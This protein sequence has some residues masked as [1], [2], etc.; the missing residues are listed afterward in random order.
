MQRKKVNHERV[1]AKRGG[2]TAF[3]FSPTR[4]PGLR[5]FNEMVP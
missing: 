2:G 5:P 4:E 1:R 3:D